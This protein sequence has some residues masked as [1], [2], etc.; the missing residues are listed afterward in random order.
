[1]EGAFCMKGM[2]AKSMAVHIGSAE[3]GSVTE[4]EVAPI[5]ASAVFKFGSLEQ[6]E[7][8]WMGKSRGYVYSRMANPS[9]E[10]FEEAV[11]GLEGAAGT[12]A[13]S[14]GMA[15]TC[16]SLDALLG[17]DERIVSASVL[18]GATRTLIEQ[19]AARRGASAEFVDITDLEEVR[20]AMEPGARAL[21]CESISNPLM[22]VADIPTLASIAHA[23]G[24]FLVVDNTFATPMLMRPLEL[25]ADVVI[26][27]CTKYINGHDDIMAG[28]V[29]VGGATSGGT[30]ILAA[31]RNSRTLLGPVLSPFE[32]WLALRGIRTLG[33]RMEKHCGNAFALAMALKSSHKVT[34]VHYPGLDAA[35]P[36]SAAARLLADGYGG[37]LSFNV[38][39]GREVVD[40]IVKNLKLAAFVPSLGSCATTISHPASTSHRGLSEEEKARTGITDGLVRVS[41]GIEQE[42]DIVSDFIGALEK[43]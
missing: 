10:A 2:S 43:L 16:I 23:A 15:A 20:T 25:G 32:A 11:D 18:Y 28:T 14:S 21:F 30:G 27:S 12:V 42:R 36:L 39:G 5:Y 35:D 6:V 9:V 29:S 33:V 19:D 3:R 17:R 41:V 7:D 37:M 1:M 38:D 13:A 26:H 24:A 34:A 40:R 8:V 22:E 31:I 4:P